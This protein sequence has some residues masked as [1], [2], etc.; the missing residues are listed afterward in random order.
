MVLQ[1]DPDLTAPSGEGVLSVKSGCPLIRG[2]ILLIFHV[3]VLPLNRGSLNRGPTVLTLSHNLNSLTFFSLNRMQQVTLTAG[4]V[5][6]TP[7]LG[8]IR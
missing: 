5:T 4:G 3:G 2:Q 1:L 7:L 8:N 6:N